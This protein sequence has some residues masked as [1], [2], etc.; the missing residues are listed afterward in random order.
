MNLKSLAF[1]IASCACFASAHADLSG[2][3]AP[4]NWAVNNTNGGNGTVVA[5]PA[6]LQLTSSNFT[7]LDLAPLDPSMLSFSILVTQAAT[8]SF[9]W[10]YVTHDDNGSSND[11]FGYAVGSTAV[12]VSVD[13]SYAAQSGS[14]TVFVNAGETFSFRT[15][16]TDNI[17][18]S[19]VTTITGFNA[20]SAV[21]EPDGLGLALV[22]LPVLGLAGRRRRP[23]A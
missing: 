22:A 6:S 13:G 18:G 10:A 23:I 19:A 8:I 2:A 5:M 4:A 21:P 1:A 20:I 9:D 11:T 7:D 15:V 12:Q 17:F 16:S 3:Y 14:K